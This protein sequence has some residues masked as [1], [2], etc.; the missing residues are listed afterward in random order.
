MIPRHLG[1]VAVLVAAV[2]L[3]QQQDRETPHL[4]HQVKAIT[5]VLAQVVAFMQGLEGAAQGLSVKM[6]LALALLGMVGMGL[7]L[8][9]LA[10]P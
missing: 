10:H 2:L 5:A 9:L 6:L 3:E 8:A 1:E 4:L 7:H